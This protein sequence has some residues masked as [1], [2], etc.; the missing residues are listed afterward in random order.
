MKLNRR[1]RKNLNYNTP[2]KVFLTKFDNN[3]AL[4]S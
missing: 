1:P 3:V 2:G 4:A